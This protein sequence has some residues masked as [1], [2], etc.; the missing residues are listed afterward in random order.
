MEEKNTNYPLILCF[1]FDKALFDMPEIL[2]AVTKSVNDTLQK[3]DA[4]AIAYFL[5]CADGDSERVECINPILVGEDKMNEINKLVE[6]IKK[7]FDIGKGA[8]KDLNNPDNEIEITE[9]CECGKNEACNCKYS[10]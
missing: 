8:D 3:R 6:D 7:Q 5:R 10:K 9:E 2:Q 1:Y 4:N